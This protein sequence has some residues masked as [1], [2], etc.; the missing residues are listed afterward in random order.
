MLTRLQ[1]LLARRRRK[2][3]ST[4]CRLRVESLESRTVLSAAHPAAL[5]LFGD[6]L[7]PAPR[8][9]SFPADHAVGS[10]PADAP[11]PQGRSG[12]VSGVLD[13]HPLATP[14]ADLGNSSHF[15]GEPA[16]PRP[17]NAGDVVPSWN[18]ELA[19]PTRDLPPRP[20]P[21]WARPIDVLA[22][23][24]SSQGTGVLPPPGRDLSVNVAWIV[25]ILSPPPL[26][27][28]SWSADSNDGLALGSHPAASSMA[29]SRVAPAAA[30]VG[31]D[32]A[33]LA[34]GRIWETGPAPIENLRGQGDSPAP[35]RPFSALEGL[36]KE[37][38]AARILDQR[39]VPE[40]RSRRPA[41]PALAPLG[42]PFDDSLLVPASTLQESR[43]SYIP[44]ASSAAIGRSYEPAVRS[45]NLQTGVSDVDAVA[46]LIALL[47]GIHRFD[48]T[49]ENEGGGVEIGDFASSIHY[50][51]STQHPV[52][53][54]PA[55]SE[56][57]CD[58]ER[59]GSRIR[60]RLRSSVRD[61]LLGGIRLAD[62]WD[63]QTAEGRTAQDRAAE[64]GGTIE[65]VVAAYS[66]A[67]WS[68][69]D[70]SEA[71]D[72]APGGDAIRDAGSG[73]IRM[74]TGVGLFQAFEL[75]AGPAEARMTPPATSGPEEEAAALAAPAGSATA[76]VGVTAERA[77]VN[78]APLELPANRALVVP[79]VLIVASLLNRAARREAQDDSSSFAPRKNGL[80]RSERRP[81]RPSLIRRS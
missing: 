23:P 43:S 48:R 71:D 11:L 53:R 13:R 69:A 19:S 7:P 46:E 58:D 2:V 34:S 78:D 16:G 24:L 10:I 59:T 17:H 62:E 5:V 54:L 40:S 64:E 32:R 4:V 3:D 26:N 30:A 60:L 21:D 14:A 50:S 49:S 25:V 9:D 81:C 12:A 63:P 28:G 39:A 55:M 67:R 77:A 76:E 8:R 31:G 75:A 37:E 57:V 15:A 1:K 61:E 35:L 41:S 38:S 42:T 45:G 56:E 68:Q 6:P 79:S 18:D 47:A 80:S 52:R 36:A 20:G 29:A 73:S 72:S 51:L 44:D 33:G 27:L 74:D 70:V 22:A 66:S 65:L